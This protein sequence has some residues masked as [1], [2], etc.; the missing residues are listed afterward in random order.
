MIAS[1]QAMRASAGRYERTPWPPI[2]DRGDQRKSGLSPQS[3]RRQ[4]RIRAVFGIGVH[5]SLPKVRRESLTQY[6]QYLSTTLAFPFGALYFDEQEGAA[7]DNVVTAARLI[8]PA[9]CLRDPRS[10]IQC[11]VLACGYPIRIRLDELRIA[12]HGPLQEAIDDY[13]YW[14]QAER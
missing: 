6:H 13:R 2:A 5:V 4:D 10:G 3:D 7:C 11:E 12:E 1:F 8:D 9:E 14:F